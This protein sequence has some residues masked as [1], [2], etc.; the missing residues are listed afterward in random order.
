M[1]D[2]ELRVRW[3]AACRDGALDAIVITFFA[4]AVLGMIYLCLWGG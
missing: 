3:W 2:D 1:T 4:G